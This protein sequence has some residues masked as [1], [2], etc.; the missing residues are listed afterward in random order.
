MHC[1]KNKKE[2]FICVTGQNDPFILI[3]FPTRQKGYIGISK[4][5][6]EFVSPS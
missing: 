3:N 1:T 6:Q 2:K 5:L 4:N